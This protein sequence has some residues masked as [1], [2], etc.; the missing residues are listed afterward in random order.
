MKQQQPTND[1]TLNVLEQYNLKYGGS[2][3]L[4]KYFAIQPVGDNKY[5]MGTKAVA[6]DENS[7]IIVDGVKYDYGHLV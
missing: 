7:D 4:D 6:I 2:R 1:H 3:V 5:E